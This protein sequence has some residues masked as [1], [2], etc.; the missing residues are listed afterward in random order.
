MLAIDVLVLT[1]V[2]IGFLN[3]AAVVVVARW[4][5]RRNPPTGQFVDAQ[6]LR[7]HYVERGGADAPAVVLFHG[8]GAT[9]QDF[10]GSGLI[11]LLAQRY[12]VICFDRPGFGHSRRPGRPA[13]SPEA[14]ADLFHVALDRLEVRQPVV[15][16][17]SWGTLVALAYAL[18]APHSQRAP[19]GVVVAAGYYF[20]TRRWDVWLAAAPA[21]PTLGDIAC[22]TISPILGA[23]LT[24]PVIRSLF[25][26]LAT[27]ESF[28]RRFSLAMTLRPSQLRAVAQESG[29]MIPA[30]ARL[31]ER[32]RDLA[33]PLAI[34]HAPGDTL[35]EPEQGPRLQQA[36]K[37][38]TLHTV[39]HAG[40]MLHYAAPDDIVRAIDGMMREPSLAGARE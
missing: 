13:L 2:L 20:P 31:Q 38:A 28:S 14:Q 32:Y 34:F 33:C 40:H 23:L 5:E 7:L 25:A 39:P 29:L 1:V 9:I 22:Y 26:P 36:V 10:A 16:G 8:N 11:D 19:R 4:A 27:P 37:G 6:G 15:F 30:A 21:L 3:A 17:H 24:P 35:I 12:R 18:R